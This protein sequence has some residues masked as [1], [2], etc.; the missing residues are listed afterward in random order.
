[1]VPLGLAPWSSIATTVVG[2]PFQ[3]PSLYPNGWLWCN[4]NVITTTG[5]TVTYQPNQIPGKTGPAHGLQQANSAVASTQTGGLING[6]PSVTYSGGAC[7][8]STDINPRFINF[9]IFMVCQFTG[10]ITNKWVINSDDFVEPA[11]E[12]NASNKPELLINDSVNAGIAG[13]TA[14]TTGVPFIYSNS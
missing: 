14:L 4:T 3:I 11:I 9:S 12:I 10:T 8:V 1:M 2:N 13:S 5:T 6:V 7:M